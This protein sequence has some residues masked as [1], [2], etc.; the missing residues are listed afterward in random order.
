VPTKHLPVCLKL[1]NLRDS[2]QRFTLFGSFAESNFA[3]FL[4][5][6]V[7]KSIIRVDKAP[8]NQ[9][10]CLLTPRISECKL[11]EQGSNSCFQAISLLDQDTLL[12]LAQDG[13]LLHIHTPTMRIGKTMK[14]RIIKELLDKPQLIVVNSCRLVVWS[15]QSSLYEVTRTNA[16]WTDWR[17]VKSHTLPEHWALHHLHFDRSSQRFLLTLKK[18][19]SRFYRLSL[20]DVD[21]NEIRVCCSLEQVPVKCLLNG[22]DCCI[23]DKLDALY[24]YSL[25]TGL[26]RIINGYY[27]GE[28]LAF[29]KEDKDFSGLLYFKNQVYTLSVISSE[30]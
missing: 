18:Y 13:T 1:V 2:D 17:L 11:T 27:K 22:N 6:R 30:E 5:D 25:E 16:H 7:N 24:L 12:T 8:T 19:D 10:S 29:R 3:F 14:L 23:Q 28:L 4:L 21:F 9:L 15:A 20:L 26:L